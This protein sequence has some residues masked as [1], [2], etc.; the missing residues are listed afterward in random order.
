LKPVSWHE[1]AEKVYLPMWR[2]RVD[3]HGHVLRGLTIAT[4]P[5]SS[6]GLV[7]IGRQL[8]EHSIER[9]PDH[10]CLG[11]AFQ[12]I[13]AALVLRLTPLGWT[14]DVQPGDDVTL[15]RAGHEL[16]PYA[17]LNAFVQ[18]RTTADEWRAQC[19]AMGIADLPLFGAP[20]AGA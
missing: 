7:A 3:R 15:R 20:A 17:V 14:V 5:P 2:E 8:F 4:L 18:G 13:L 6:A 9:P 19:T 1:V 11:R 10:E 12:L 16:R